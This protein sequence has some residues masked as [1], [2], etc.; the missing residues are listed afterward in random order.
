MLA[1]CF[2][3]FFL[4]LVFGGCKKKAEVT[5]P[6]SI[7]PAEEGAQAQEPEAAEEPA[8][9]IEAIS[10]DLDEVDEIESELNPDDMGGLDNEL[11]EINW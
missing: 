1:V 5:A 4:L 8:D 11:D 2:A 9:E 7:T 10:S 3:L 6:E